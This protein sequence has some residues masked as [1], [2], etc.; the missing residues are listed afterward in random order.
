MFKPIQRRIPALIKDSDEMLLNLQMKQ[1]LLENSDVIKPA[2]T[3]IPLSSQKQSG[4][5]LSICLSLPVLRRLSL[6]CNSCKCLYQISLWFRVS[7][8]VESLK[9]MTIR[10]R[11]DKRTE[12][13]IILIEYVSHFFLLVQLNIPH[14]PHLHP[15]HNGLERVAILQNHRKS[16]CRACS[17]LEGA[18]F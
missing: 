7:G 14:W 2:S 12:I 1:T 6:W 16:Y 5:F 17:K 13:N 11:R 9:I 15:H 10:I 3:A 4:V 18:Q 8:P